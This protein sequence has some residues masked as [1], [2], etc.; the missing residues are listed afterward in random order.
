M[1]GKAEP[2]SPRSKK[3]D[4]QLRRSTKV[5]EIVR[6]DV[7]WFADSI[8]RSTRLDDCEKDVCK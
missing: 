7:S 4:F 6:V 2:I 1:S 8:S 5:N 3:K